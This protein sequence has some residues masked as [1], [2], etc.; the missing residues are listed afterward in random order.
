M[1]LTGTGTFTSVQEDLWAT[2]QSYVITLSRLLALWASILQPLE[3][4]FD[5][6]LHL[7]GGQGA[8]DAAKVRGE[9]RTVRHIEVDM[10]Q[11]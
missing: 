1:R 4:N 3:E 9:R 7:T 8:E 6:E 2:I 10:V 11:R 5:P